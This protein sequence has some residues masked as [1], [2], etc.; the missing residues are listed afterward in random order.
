MK[1]KKSSSNNWWIILGF[2][3]I[4]VVGNAVR[5]DFGG[6]IASVVTFPALIIWAIVGGLYGVGEPDEP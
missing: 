2:L 3:L 5:N 6:L 1:L 4:L